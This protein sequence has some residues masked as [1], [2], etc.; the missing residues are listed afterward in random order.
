MSTNKKALSVF[1][2]SALFFSLIIPA[3]DPAAK[4]SAAA[5]SAL[6]Y[7]DIPYVTQNEIDAIE[8]LKSSVDKFIYGQMRETEAFEL[9][10]GTVSGFAA[11]FCKLLTGLF[12]IEFSL[13][14]Q[15]W[16]TLKNGIDSMETDFTGDL[17]PTPERMLRYFMTY[18]IAERSLRIFTYAGKF[19]ILTERD[20]NGLKVGSLTG[21]IDTEHVMQYYPELIFTVVDVESFDAAADMLKTGEIDVFISEGV[22]DPIF[23]DYGFIDSKEFFPLVYTSVSLTTA[24]PELEPIID[25]VNK[26]LSAGGIDTLYDL[27]KKGNK[28]Y[29]R[30]K[31]NKSLTEEES[32]YLND[33][34]RR[35]ATVKI[36]LEQD[37]YPICFYD[38]TAK[39]FHGI[40][41][42]VIEEISR[43]TGIEFEVV[44]DENTPWS[45]V[46]EMLRTGKASLVSQLLY[47]DERKGSFLWTETPYA[48][49]YYAL[50]SKYEHPSIASYQV[51]RTR[52][53]TINKSAFEDKYREWF[54]ENDNLIPYDSQIDVLDALEAGEIDLLMGSDYLL[55]MQQNF[56]EKP[57]FKINIRFGAPMY[58]YFGFNK[59]EAILCS[60]INKTQSFVDLTEI[61]DNWTSRGYDYAKN[62]ARQR[63]VL[64]MSVAGFLSV[65]LLLTVFFLIRNRRLNL[66]LD[67]T[68]KERTSELELKDNLLNTVNGAAEILLQSETDVFAE[69]LL[70]CMEMLAGPADADRLSIWKNRV[71]AESGKRYCVRQFEWSKTS[72]PRQDKTNSTSISYDEYMPMWE[73]MLARGNCVNGSIKDMTGPERALLEK[74]GVSSVLLVPILLQELFWGF[75]SFADCHGERLFSENEESVLRSGG[76]V[77]AN[78]LLRN[79]MTLKIHASAAEMAAVLRNYAGVIWSVDTDNT[80]T[81]FDG[82]YLKEIDLSSDSLTGKKLEAAQEKYVGF[83]LSEHVR[84]TLDKGPQ[85]W[86]SEL[87]GKMFSLHTNPIRDEAGNIS[88]VVGSIDDIT[89]TIRLRKELEIALEKAE[90]GVHALEAAKQTVDAMFGANPHMNI[91]FDNSFKVVDCNPA[92]YEFMGFSTKEE[93]LTGFIERMTKS[94]PEYQS[95]GRVSISLAERLMTAA[96]EGWARFETEL[97]MGDLTKILN[98]EFKRIPYEK[99]FAVV[100]YVFD[101]TEIREREKELIERDR[102][103]IE[104]VE[105]AKAANRAKSE[106]LS[107]M[108]HEIRTPMNAILGITEI[109]LQDESLD[110]ETKESLDKIYSSGDLLLGIINDILD[111]SKIEAGKL[112]LIVTDYEA[113][114]LINDTAQ[115]NMMRIGSKPIEFELSVDENMPSVLTG[116]ELRV[117][118]I[119]NNLLSNAFKYTARGTVRLS[120]GAE[121]FEDG[122]SETDVMLVI[123]VSDTGQGM[124]EEQISKLFDEYS[125]FNQEANRTTEGTGLGM[126]IT[127]N[128]IQMMNGEISVKSEPG[129]G[130]EFT[131]RIPQGSPASGLIGRELAENLQQFRMNNSTQM[132]RVQITRDPMPY[133]SVLIVD[134]VETNIYVATGLMMP[135]ELKI[136]S[137]DSGFA[138]IEKIREGN[139][140]D[141]VFM[142]HMMPKMDGIEATKIIRDMGYEHIIVALTANAVAGQAEIFLANGFS[143]FIS[144]PIDIRQLNAVLN[145]YVRD[146]QPP[147]VIEA[148]KAGKREKEA[149]KPQGDAGGALKQ[150]PALDPRFAEIFVR[151]ASKSLAV[152]DDLI[153][154]GGALGEDDLRTYTINAHGMKSAL[155]NIGRSEMS[156]SAMKLE[157]A[158]R[159]G[160]TGVITEHTPAF[161]SSLRELLKELTPKKAENAAKGAEDEDRAHLFEKLAELK[162]ACE[163]LNKKEA[164]NIVSELREKNWSEATGDMLGNVA[165]HL[166]HSDFEE[167]LRVVADFGSDS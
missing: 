14:L 24:N 40:A 137:A 77:I 97:V 164:K 116:D 53:G 26:F 36:A 85:D 60:V 96:K 18:P 19:E 131:V 142:D 147:E 122:A 146:K 62:I 109:R 166:L 111:L 157:E 57:G 68:V 141:I 112:E 95:D 6:Y 22:I 138:A 106:F 1:V 32:E 51:V 102:Q 163:A 27:Y 83:E 128:L 120:V 100:A 155:A 148:A 113:A 46:L 127:R 13:E 42:D 140:Y 86:I 50:L 107:N 64:S 132:K 71:D 74:Q 76:M 134:D 108:S 44:T 99:T 167:V 66:S 63:A 38:T 47:S 165:E 82:L 130:S 52:V 101:M 126:S 7:S 89:E 17:T 114:S 2:A 21:T 15:D 152:L 55:L 94:I 69:N 39:E 143:D 9:K 104:A 61:A 16:E 72:G 12:G 119:M 90:A 151:D 136:D 5:S 149:G 160:D 79:E 75:V 153:K 37:N 54:P 161:L 105:E 29:A 118:Q 41:V 158:G 73:G 93:L 45:E 92:A 56:R 28:E 145:K 30:Y 159:A 150:T 162:A 110:R 125:R 34:I 135:Y 31:L 70:R 4:A 33:L 98:V 3:G 35:N 8:A 121:P 59:D 80:I 81:L 87:D 25:V 43:L 49:S 20:I 88:G 48:S 124:T 11:E 10:D 84:A 65:L 115:L 144:K 154:K 129:K 139:V 58:S 133:G 23:D 91:L 117:K 123:G 78:A 67:K 156:S 103:L